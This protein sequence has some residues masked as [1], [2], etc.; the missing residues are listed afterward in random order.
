MSENSGKRKIALKNV[1]I[2]DGE[3]IKE[4]STVVIDGGIIGKPDDT[5]DAEIIDGKGCVLLPGFID[6]HVHLHGEENLFQLASYGVTTALDM[7]NGLDVYEP[8]RARKGLTD[9]RSALTVATSPG[10]RHS[11]LF[12]HRGIPE[13]ELVSNPEDARNFV[14]RRVAEGSDYIKIIADVPG[15]DQASL[16]ALAAAA[17]SHGK[18]VVAH[19]TAYIPCQM[20]QEAGVD[21]LTHAPVDRAFE[22]ADVDRM[23]DD[24]RIIVPTLT[25]IETLLRNVKRPGADYSHGRETVRALYRAGVPVLAGTDANQAPALPFNVAHGESLHRELELLVDAGLS[26]VDTLRAA[27]SLPA[28]HFGLNDRGVIEPG[29]RAD[30]VLIDG[31]PVADIRATRS[32]RHVWCGGLEYTPVVTTAHL[33]V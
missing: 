3:G 21:V 29:Y 4:P 25:V 20:A 9:V 7:G 17:H 18:L 11:K 30:L 14:A 31:D 33:N 27:T 23:I 8:L 24:K 13:S 12:A 1:R 26:T 6:A 16:N 22:K 15:P 2:F 19:A 28:K 10:S 32:I 5:E